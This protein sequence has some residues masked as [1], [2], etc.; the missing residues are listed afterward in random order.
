M[1][2]IL[3]F[4]RAMPFDPTNRRMSSDGVRIWRGP[5]DGDG[6]EDEPEQDTRSL[7]LTEV[8]FGKVLFE[9]CLEGWE[10][11][12]RG[13]D[14]LARHLKTGRVRLDAQIG[15]YLLEEKGQA[16]LKWLYDNIGIDWF[17]LPGTVLRHRNSSRFLFCLH[18]TKDGWDSD[19]SFLDG[20]RQRQDVSAMYL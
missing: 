12:I 16:T 20:V 18:R 8:D 7:A 3:R 17:E 19:Y 14:K 2:R 1:E 6:L 10:E 9:H 11:A 13:E 15:Q 5:R 4:S